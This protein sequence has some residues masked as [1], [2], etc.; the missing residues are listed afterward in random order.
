MN[1]LEEL[2]TY[3]SQAV[4]FTADTTVV[5]RTV[6]Q[7]FISPYMTWT[8]IRQLGNLTGNGAQ[9]SYNVGNV[10]NTT[11]QFNSTAQSANP[12]TVTSPTTGVYV[13]KGILEQQDYFAAVA[14]IVPQV[15]NTGNVAYTAT[16]TNT[17]NAGALQPTFVVSYV[18]V[19][20]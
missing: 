18:G 7:N 2:N 9:V 11:V 8:P 14:T 13:I 1:K 15:G 5:P 3:S 4:Y 10:G 12:L 16:Y 17:N 6:A 20:T 19:P